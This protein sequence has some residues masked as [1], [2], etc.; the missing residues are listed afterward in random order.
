M[1]LDKKQRMN[2]IMIELI[3]PMTIFVIIGMSAWRIRGTRGFGAIPG[4]VYAG[5]LWSILWLYMSRQFKDQDVRPFSSGW[6]FMGLAFGIALN[7]MH[8]WMQWPF[9][10]MGQLYQG[11]ADPQYAV[12]PVY[13]YIWLF[14]C[15]VPWCGI[16]AVGLAW[17]NRR[18]SLKSKDWIFRLVSGV[19]GGVVAYITW[20]IFRPVLIPRYDVVMANYDTGCYKCEDPITDTRESMIWFGIYLGFLTFEILKK[21]WINVKLILLCGL[22]AGFGWIILQSWFFG[23]EIFPDLPRPLFDKY[24]WGF[25]E[26]T[27]GIPFGLAFGLSFYLFNRVKYS[28]NTATSTS[29]N[30]EH[31]SMPSGTRN[32]KGAWKKNLEALVAI[33]ITTIIA[34]LFNVN[35]TF[36]GIISILT[37]YRPSIV[38]E[39]VIPTLIACIGFYIYHV[40]RVSRRRHPLNTG[41]DHLK[42]TSKLLPAMLVFTSI[43]G[44]ITS[45][46]VESPFNYWANFH[47]LALIIAIAL[48]FMRRRLHAFNIQRK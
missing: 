3:I 48:L 13:G 20:L 29:L 35:S 24:H 6:S 46:V 28:R 23:R 32:S 39:A 15:A 26:L 11:G 4:C 7:G 2:E 33:D 30:Q 36:E 17:A 10:T 1:D 40:T 47:V 25:W 31:A 8:A 41:W 19:A 16:G 22:I 43:L 14:I 34:V 12:S 27:A 45:T 38:L 5:F 21:H 37:G 9:W 42:Y 18:I 44:I